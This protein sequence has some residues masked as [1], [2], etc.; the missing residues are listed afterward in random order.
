MNAAEL[1]TRLDELD[2]QV[3]AAGDRLRF[4]PAGRVDDQLRAELQDHKAEL[5]RLL[6]GQSLGESL[7]GGVVPAQ[8]SL[9]AEDVCQMRLSEFASAGLVVTVYS[10]VLN[11][12]IVFASDNAVVDPG[13]R[14]PVYRAAELLEVLDLA[15]RD[16]RC[17]HRVK[18]IF[19]GTLK[20]S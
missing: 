16:L 5:L 9:L 3:E 11:E 12:T 14:R 6:K 15:P 4:R 17:L 10:E 13:G 19:G 8:R 2:I 18:K 20:P 7:P 1:R